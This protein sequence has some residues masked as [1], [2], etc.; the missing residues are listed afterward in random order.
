MNKFVCILSLLL[1]LIWHFQHS[2]SI[3]SVTKQVLKQNSKYAFFHK[4][5]SEH[6]KQHS[7]KSTY[8]VCIHKS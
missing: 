7:L 8:F 6:E 5:Y 4:L 3:F 2:E 1:L